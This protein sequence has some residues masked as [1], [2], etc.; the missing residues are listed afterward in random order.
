MDPGLPYIIYN[1]C[2][3]VNGDFIFRRVIIH[4]WTDGYTKFGG[5][6]F[7]YRKWHEKKNAKSTIILQ[8][9]RWNVLAFFFIL[10]VYLY[11]TLIHL[12]SGVKDKIEKKNYKILFSKN[13]IIIIRSPKNSRN[14]S[15][16]IHIKYIGVWIAP[17]KYHLFYNPSPFVCKHTHYAYSRTLFIV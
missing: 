16:S 2:N 5:W 4:G 3:R 17:E 11:Y 13:K 9:N 14:R 12:W 15:P 6:L 8:P 1:G 10:L 7:L